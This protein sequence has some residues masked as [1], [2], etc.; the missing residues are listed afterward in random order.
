MNKRIQQAQQERLHMLERLAVV[1][2][3]VPMTEEEFHLWE[4]ADEEYV[5]PLIKKYLHTPGQVSQLF[6]MDATIEDALN[7]RIAGEE[8]HEVIAAMFSDWNE[9]LGSKRFGHY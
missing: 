8:N 4:N 1:N 3:R 9:K 6:A 2:K 7:G 5:V